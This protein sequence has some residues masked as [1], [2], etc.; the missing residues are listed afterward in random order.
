MRKSTFGAWLGLALLCY[1]QTGQHTWKEVCNC[2]T[3]A[4][5]VGA[6]I[7]S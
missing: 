5:A 1:A 7:Y 2:T 6:N 4:I 3:L